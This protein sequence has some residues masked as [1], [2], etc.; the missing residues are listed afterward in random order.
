MLTSSAIPRAAR[1]DLG[2][3]AGTRGNSAP[4]RVAMRRC[5]EEAAAMRASAHLRTSA[6]DPKSRFLTDLF[7]IT[8]FSRRIHCPRSAGPDPVCKSP[9]HKAAVKTGGATRPRIAPSNVVISNK[10]GRNRDFGSH[11]A[12]PGA[13]PSRSAVVPR[14]TGRSGRP[15]HGRAPSATRSLPVQCAFPFDLFSCAWHLRK[16][17]KSSL[18]VLHLE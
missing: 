4:M 12:R 16:A 13:E 7:E 2:R 11:G 6:C 17:P 8:T 1:P 10:S 14:G 3:R 9:A 15:G 5:A 18:R